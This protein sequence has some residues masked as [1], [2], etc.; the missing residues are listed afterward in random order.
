MTGQAPIFIMASE[1]QPLSA[2]NT[3]ILQP[4]RSACYHTVCASRPGDRCLVRVLSRLRPARLAWTG[5]RKVRTPQ[6]SVL[7]NGEGRRRMV[8]TGTPPVRKVPQKIYRPAGRDKG[9]KVRAA[10][11]ALM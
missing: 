10:Q 9:E 11:A 8:S 5:E 6:G 3:G 1:F 2:P 7:A 4:A